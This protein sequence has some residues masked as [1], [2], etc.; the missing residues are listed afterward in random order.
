MLTIQS[1]I[2]ASF[3][4]GLSGPPGE[5]RKLRRE[6]GESRK[7]GAG[8]IGKQSRSPDFPCGWFPWGPNQI[9]D[10][11]VEDPNNCRLENA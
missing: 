9:K 8:R 4:S 1:W 10:V 5:L 6:I 11:P 3:Q 2:P 7:A